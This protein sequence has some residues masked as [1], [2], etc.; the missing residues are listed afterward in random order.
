MSEYLGSIF[1]NKEI[2]ILILWEFHYHEK[3]VICRGGKINV[4]WLFSEFFCKSLA[5]LKNWKNITLT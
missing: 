5:L 2:Y 1:D 4:T 3:G